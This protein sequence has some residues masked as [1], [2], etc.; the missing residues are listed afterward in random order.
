MKRYKGR[1]INDKML[2]TCP[3]RVI[4]IPVENVQES[5]MIELRREIDA[6]CFPAVMEK[7]KRTVLQKA[8]P[9]IGTAALFAGA[10]AAVVYLAPALGTILFALIAW[11]MFAAAMT[12]KKQ[13]GKQ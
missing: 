5:G 13:E 8:A 1:Y 2:R 3:D 11:L 7:P 4:E 12:E 6:W 9:A 10:A